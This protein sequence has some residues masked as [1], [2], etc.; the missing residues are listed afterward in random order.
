[1]EDTDDLRG[2]EFAG[3]GRLTSMGTSMG[4]SSP[5][6]LLF[7]GSSPP[8][9]TA[10]GGGMQLFAPDFVLFEL[11]PFVCLHS[12]L[13]I[14]LTIPYSPIPSMLP[15]A[16]SVVIKVVIDSENNKLENTETGKLQTGK[17]QTRK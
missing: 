17:L 6:L 14:S 15:V 10:G 16:T 9:G 11:F 4:P 2:R 5:L 7:N 3:M 12:S 1:M 13:V 8:A